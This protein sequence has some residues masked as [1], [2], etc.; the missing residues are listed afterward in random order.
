MEVAVAVPAPSPWSVSEGIIISAPCPFVVSGSAPGD[1]ASGSEG[2]TISCSSQQVDKMSFVEF[3][4][5]VG[6]RS[7]KE[8]VNADKQQRGFEHRGNGRD[9]GKD[10]PSRDR[11]RT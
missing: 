7:A 2:S 10:R 1:E 6:Y 3:Q 8:V 11:S 4:S 5:Y 9:S